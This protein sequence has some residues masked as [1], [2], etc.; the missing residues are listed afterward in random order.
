MPA[1]TRHSRKA[2]ESLT[3]RRMTRTSD[4]PPSSL[5][6]PRARPLHATP[7]EVNG[8]RFVLLRDPLGLLPEGFAIS[9][10]LYGVLACCDG[11]ETLAGIQAGLVSMLG[12]FVSQDEVQSAVS[13]LRRHGLIEGPEIARL[14]EDRLRAYRSVP[15]P[16]SQAG[17][18]YPSDASELSRY[19]DTL[20]DRD[21]PDLSP[22]V[23][24]R[25]VVAPHIDF[26]RGGEVYGEAYALAR[27]HLAPDT[28]IV[29]G[30]SHVPSRQPYILTTQPFDTPLGVVDVDGEI[31]DRLAGV[32]GDDAFTDELLHVQE[33]S[34]EF[35]AVFIKH[36]FPNARAVPI[37]CSEVGEDDGE[38]PPQAGDLAREIRAVLDH[39]SGAAA[40]VAAVDLSHVGP[41][42]GHDAPADDGVK[43]WASEVDRAVMRSALAG[44]ARGVL[45]ASARRNA[46]GEE[47]NVCGQAALYLAALAVAPCMGTVLRLAQAPTPD[48]TSVV[49]FAAAAIWARPD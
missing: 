6:R 46:A 30:V 40:L 2:R 32:L 36:L 39:R 49:G 47:A 42:F 44:N 11:T 10:P 21:P 16:A 8:Q 20:L 1:G 48:G 28:F 27:R 34:I 17:A 9:A 18:A 38:G 4:V 19:L 7:L 15:R 43:A 37:L 35:Q 23:S 41:E 25:C 14:V 22:E 3:L 13:E 12:T 26:G 24:V 31:V 5:D 45:E 29:L 33:H